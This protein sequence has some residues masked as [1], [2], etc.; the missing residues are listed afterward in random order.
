MQYAHIIIVYVCVNH[1]VR[2]NCEMDSSLLR[3][4]VDTVYTYVPL[5]LTTEVYRRDTCI[6]S[7][8]GN[9]ETSERTS[10]HHPVTG[11][12]LGARTGRSHTGEF[13]VFR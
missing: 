2:F 3:T 13:R 8:K 6:D 10:L 1:G 7:N 12:G 9:A 4:Y 11:S 5:L